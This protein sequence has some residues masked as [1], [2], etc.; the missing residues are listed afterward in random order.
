MKTLR[1]AI[2]VT[3]GILLA[4][5]PAFA[6]KDVK[7]LKY[8]PLNPFEI[9]KPDK[10]TL[11]NGLT[12]YL[13][14]DA[15]LP[16]VSIFVRMNRCGSFLEPAPKT[17]LAGMTGAVMR[18][19]GTTSMTGDKIDELLEGIGASVETGIGDVAGTAS[20]NGLSEHAET[21]IKTLA[22]I[23]RN[24]VF[25]QDKIELEKTSMR[26][27]ISRRNDEPMS[28]AQREFAKM[29]YGADSPYG[30]HTEYAT[31]DAITRDD[32]VGFHK[33]TFQPNN[34]QIAVW[35]DFR[36]DQIV[37]LIKK[38]FG[39]WARG[40]WDAPP[41]PQVDYTFKPT[42]YHA[43]KSDINQSTILIGH[44]GGKIGDPDYANVTVM[45]SVLGDGFA[46]RLFR[47]VRTKMGLAYGSGGSYTFNYDYPGIFYA[48]TMTKSETTVK[49]IRAMLEQIK[50]MQT[51]PADAMEMKLGRDG[52]LNSFVFNFDTKGKV[53]NR[54]M[55]YDHYG[56]PVDYLQKVKEGVEK[57]T[58]QDILDVSKRK[59]NPDNLQILVVGKAAD[60]DEPLSALGNVKE[61]DIAIP[62]PKSQEFAASDEELAAG[63]ALLVKS[64][65]ACG[66]VANFKKVKSVVTDAKVTINTPQGAMTI[67]VSKFEIMPDKSAQIVK[68]PMGEQ[69][70]VFDGTSGWMSAMGKSQAMPS[71]ELE[72]MKKGITRNIVWLFANAEQADF[73]IA[74]KGAAEFD[75]KPA[76]K[77]DFLFADGNQFSLF[78]DPASSLPLGMSYMGMSMAGPGEIIESYADFKPFGGVMLPTKMVQKAGGMSFEGEMVKIDVNGKIDETMF[79][80]PEGI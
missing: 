13:L 22:D 25:D 79:N 19:G 68:T 59:L 11:D 45:N 36:Q 15:S 46:S 38:Y 58:P 12:L 35:G 56:L 76:Q 5:A 3:I 21:I 40:Q 78:V 71:A 60:F 6:Q 54:M 39:D 34:T 66:G 32:M 65:K 64:A 52:Y 74:D 2:V 48:Y 4:F 17:G 23:M 37:G 33:L 61:I 70:I 30:R 69:T 20:A 47:I 62:Q 80:K 26:S 1:I 16:R 29:I 27:D 72:D 8:P 53:I 44:I 7:K 51:V 63:T 24:P 28:I 31:I 49:A 10:I 42:V 18:T 67:D 9:P 73:K 57:S 41:P 14:E 77:L 55:T 50:S 43:E 75:G